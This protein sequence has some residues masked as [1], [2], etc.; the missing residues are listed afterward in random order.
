MKN[1]IDFYKIDSGKL[2]AI[3]LNNMIPIPD[4][5]FTFIDTTAPCLTDTELKYQNLLRNQIYWLNRDG[6]SLRAR[7][8]KLYNDRKNNKLKFH[9]ADRC[10]DFILLE[11][12]CIEYIKVHE[13]LRNV[14]HIDNKENL[15]FIYDNLNDKNQFENVIVY[16]D[17]IDLKTN[18]QDM[19]KEEINDI[20]RNL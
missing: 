19:S 8:E 2:G 17:N 16:L 3:N 6:I 20:V 5:E 15:F 11:E 9:I 7:A 12:K 1:T 4:T 13:A 14:Q 10:C 18:I